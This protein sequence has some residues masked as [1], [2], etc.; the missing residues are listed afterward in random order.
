VGFF[1]E[2]V[3]G[4]VLF[5]YP[6]SGILAWLYSL[7]AASRGSSEEPVLPILSQEI[8]LLVKALEPHGLSPYNFIGPGRSNNKPTDSH[9]T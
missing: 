7:F 5:S 4:A 3:L 8:R 1:V 6:P 9:T 2:W